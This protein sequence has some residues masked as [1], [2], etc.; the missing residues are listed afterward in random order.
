M[1]FNAPKSRINTGIMATAPAASNI[2]T[3]KTMNFANF[4][5]PFISSAETESC[6]M[7]RPDR[8]ILFPSATEKIIVTVMTPSP[9]V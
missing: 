5:I 9:P 2:S 8:P 1:P 4:T 7:L 3:P 6:I